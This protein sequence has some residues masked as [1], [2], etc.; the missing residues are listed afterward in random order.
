MTVAVPTLILP[1]PIE[2]MPHELTLLLEGFVSVFPATSFESPDGVVLFHEALEARKLKLGDD[3]P[4]TLETKNDL[5]VLYKEQGRYEESEKYLLEAVKGRLSKLGDKHPHTIESLKN[6]FDLYEAW[7]K[8]EK[9][10]EWRA[11]LPQTET[12][13]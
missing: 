9:A 1:P 4:A 6:L 11:K 5:A 2:Y 8:P 10:K 7:N 13:N 12:L 3:H